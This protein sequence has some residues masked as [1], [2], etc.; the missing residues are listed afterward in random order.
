MKTLTHVQKIRQENQTVK[1][2]VEQ[3]LGWDNH[4]YCHFQE[5]MGYR[6]LAE[7]TNNDPAAKELVYMKSFWN[8]WKNQW[9][10]RDIQFLK[11]VMNVGGKLP[12]SIYKASKIANTYQQYHKVNAMLFEPHKE[13]IR[14]SYARFIGKLNKEVVNG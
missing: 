4:T 11:D 8:W 3:L 1:A 7:E 12:N 14:E 6:Y 2:K 5:E 10:K 9:I 13:V